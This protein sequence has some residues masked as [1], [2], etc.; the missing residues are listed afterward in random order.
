M[1]PTAAGLAETALTG[2]LHTAARIDEAAAFPHRRLCCPLGSIGTMAASDA[3]PAGRPFPEVI[4][5]RTP[6]SDNNMS[7]G[8]RAGEGLP[9][10]RRHYLNVPR[11]IR[12]GVPRGCDPGATPL[13][14]PSPR[15]RRARLSP[16][17]AFRAAE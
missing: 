17:P 12:R 16:V 14:W 10:S 7:A 6:R 8:C 15:S 5:Y 11:P 13:P 4:G 1:D 9:S 3:L 2:P